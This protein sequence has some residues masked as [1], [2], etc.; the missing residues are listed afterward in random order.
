MNDEN[1]RLR[2]AYIASE[3]DIESISHK[4]SMLSTLLDDRGQGVGFLGGIGF[5]ISVRRF[6][7]SVSFANVG[8]SLAR[9]IGKAEGAGADI[10]V[11]PESG[12]PP[13]LIE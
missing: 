8:S 7:E 13:E 4:H 11:I 3:A 1:P 6:G 10:L 12:K 5:A 9:L 2:K